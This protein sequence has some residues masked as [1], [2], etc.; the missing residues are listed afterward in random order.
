MTT[1][2]EQRAGDYV[3][4]RDDLRDY[5]YGYPNPGDSV[6]R[7]GPAWS[8]SLAWTHCICFA[9]SLQAVAPLLLRIDQQEMA[10]RAARDFITSHPAVR[11]EWPLLVGVIDHA[12]GSE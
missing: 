5:H 11:G 2:T 3:L 8:D 1:R 9:S 7:H 6:H 4:S 12:L 10:L